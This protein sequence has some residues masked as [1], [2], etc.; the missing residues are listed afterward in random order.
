MAVLNTISHGMGVIPL[1]HAPCF[2]DVS[3]EYLW[4]IDPLDGTA[5]FS[6][7]ACQTFVLPI[8]CGH[9]RFESS[10]H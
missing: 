3:S 2:R 7:G 10:L 9:R 4:S 5:N 1:T 6:T 8:A